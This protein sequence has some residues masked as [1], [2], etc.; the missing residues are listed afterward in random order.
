MASLNPV[1]GA[2]G[3]RRAAHLLRRATFGPTKQEINQFAGMTANQA[4]A[5]LFQT[6]TAPGA[7]Q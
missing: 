4:I 6:P 3:R 1:S 2:L 7:T 5:Q